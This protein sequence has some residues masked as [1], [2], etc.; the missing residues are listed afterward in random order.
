MAGRT[1]A[2]LK[3]SA[4]RLFMNVFVAGDTLRRFEV[5]PFVFRQF[6]LF[7]H[8]MALSAFQFGMLSDQFILGFLEM[9]EWAGRFPGR[10]GMASVAILLGPL[11][12]EEMD[13]V[14]A[15]ATDTSRGGA[16][17]ACFILSDHH[18][19]AFTDVTFSTA[20][21][22]VLAVKRV[23]RQLLVIKILL[24]HDNGV[25]VATLMVRVTFTT[26]LL[27]QSVEATL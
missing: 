1:L 22:G 13:V 19:G 12:F 9:I 4:E 23:T 7:V 15:V 17:P 10:C 27:R 20:D 21:L 3:T 2:I 14:F 16:E 18:F 24:I 11:A 25:E 6:L 5:G 8:D 26:A